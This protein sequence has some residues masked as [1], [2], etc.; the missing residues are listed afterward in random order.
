MVDNS[1]KGGCIIF[2]VR[3]ILM[4]TVHDYPGGND[5][6]KC[7]VQ[8]YHACPIRGLKLHACYNFHLKK[9]VYKDHNKFLPMDHHMRR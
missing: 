3:A 4:W 6:S 9:M 7:S 2:N 5:V 8:G 1:Q